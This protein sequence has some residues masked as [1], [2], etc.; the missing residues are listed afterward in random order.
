MGSW[1]HTATG[2]NKNDSRITRRSN[3]FSKAS[4]I[5]RTR[6]AH[7]VTRASL[8]EAM[9]KKDYEK[10]SRTKRLMGQPNHLLN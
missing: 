5:T 6:E 1:K 3:F 10:C 9:M 7:Q 8:H 2:A 4:H